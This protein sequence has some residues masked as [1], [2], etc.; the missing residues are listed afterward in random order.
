MSLNFTEDFKIGN[1]L[2]V[3]EWKQTGQPLLG[4]YES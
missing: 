4:R 2:D 3:Q 1:W